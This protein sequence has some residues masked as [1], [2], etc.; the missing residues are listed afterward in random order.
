MSPDALER[1][2]LSP[3]GT[4][5]PYAVSA[6]G[7]ACTAQ[8]ADRG[9]L[10]ECPACGRYIAFDP[11]LGRLGH[12]RHV[13]PGPC[14]LDDPAGRISFARAKLGAVLAAAVDGNGPWPWVVT[15]CA[16]GVEAFRDLRGTFVRHEE[17]PLDEGVDFRLI[18]ANEKNVMTLFLRDDSDAVRYLHD[19]YPHRF[20]V[21][22]SYR[23]L[24]HPSNWLLGEIEGVRNYRGV[25][26][27][28]CPLC[29]NRTEAA[30]G[31]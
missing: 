2:A 23:A 31:S 6:E 16:C 27:P 24:W 25:S 5:V 11:S 20:I 12:F 19:T 30:V 17:G 9:A 8:Q 10:Y 28:P 26:L 21:L 18:G 22:D 4:P 14:P 13:L 1:L 7:T 3:S 15:K 29:S